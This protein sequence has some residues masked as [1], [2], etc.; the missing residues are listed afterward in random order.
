MLSSCRRDGLSDAFWALVGGAFAASPAAIAALWN[1]FVKNPPEALGA[2]H[3][4]EVLILV[5]TVTPAIA[6]G[7]VNQ[8]R[9]EEG[10]KLVTTIRARV[11]R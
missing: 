8:S 6:I 7:L 11:P 2:L 10:E 3:L 4:M 9:K 5:G 1:A